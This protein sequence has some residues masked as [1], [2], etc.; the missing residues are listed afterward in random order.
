MGKEVAN[1]GAVGVNSKENPRG[2]IDT[3]FIFDEVLDPH[4]LTRSDGKGR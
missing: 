1:G 3:E 4:H 2:D